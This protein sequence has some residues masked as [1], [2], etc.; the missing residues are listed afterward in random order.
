MRIMD[1][2]IIIGD[3]R[4]EL[5]KFDEATF[6][7]C[8]TDPPYE[9][10][11]MGKVWDN[12]GIAFDPTFWGEVF[13]VLKP[14]AHLLAFGGTRTYHRMVCAIE[15]A[16]FGIRDQIDWIYGSGFPKSK[17]IGTGF[18]TALKPAHEPICLARK[19]L[20][21][22]LTVADNVAKWGVGAL[23]IDG[24]R[25]EYE[26]GGSLATNP[27]LRPFVKG[28]N[29]G[30]II[31]HE[32]DSR[33]TVANN[34]GRWPANIIHD[35]SPEVLAAF[36]NAPGQIADASTNSDSRKTQNCYGDM[37]R[38][39]GDEPSADS[40]NNGE[41]GFK[42]R[43]GARRL[44]E[45]SAARFFYC[46]K[47]SKT[48]RNEGCDDLAIGQATGG[49]GG[50]GDYL[51]DVNSASGKYGSEK[52]P[53]Q[54]H[55]PTVKP[56]DLMRYLC[57]LITPPNGLILDPFLG[58]GSTAKAATIERF[59]CVGIEQNAEYA[60]IAEARCKGLQTSLL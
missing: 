38:G 13:R 23:N 1:S 56:T 15:D 55:H 30:N 7:A 53:S 32:V 57:R 10:G 29:G 40:D 16:G 41:V 5:P 6:D 28:G 9:L 34:L 54:N 48:D 21:K 19:P 3:S 42:M 60:A 27:S 51:E 22:G 24:C 58:S 45:G 35:G 17:N 49:G 4:A 59:R 18:G 52:A 26:E 46:A 25:V 44:D 14:G 2:R 12:S 47:A 11:F 43:P 20:E 31:A 50:I 36:P 33:E 8:V 39:R 37:R